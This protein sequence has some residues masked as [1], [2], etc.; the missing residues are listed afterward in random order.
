MITKELQSTI[1]AALSEAR[2]RRHEYLCLEHLL[3]SLA[4]EQTGSGVLVSLG[5]DVAVAGPASAGGW[6]I[7]IA[8]D[9]AA[10]LGD[11]GPTVSVQLGGLASSGTAVRRWRSGGV[12][13][14]HVI[15]PR[16][17]RPAP[18][19]WRTVSVAAASC[20]DALPRREAHR[21]LGAR[22]GRGASRGPK[23]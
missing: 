2:K 10:S 23:C 3:Y 11:A 21:R 17:G 18:T 22:T 14:H 13:V 5:G 1:L 20:V 12:E 19:P 4:A 15:D 16:S 7:R 9:H 8:D 6:P